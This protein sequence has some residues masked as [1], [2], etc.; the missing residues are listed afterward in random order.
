MELE[1]KYTNSMTKIFTRVDDTKEQ[2]R[3]KA[4]S[5]SGIKAFRKTNSKNARTTS[6]AEEILAE[7]EAIFSV[8]GESDESGKLAV[9]A[10]QD[11]ITE[12]EDGVKREINEEIN[13]SGGNTRL[14]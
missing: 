8:L 4:F 9:Q 7:F 14:Y 6:A 13:N 10:E 2:K 3:K 1:E 11:L 12:I 5:Q